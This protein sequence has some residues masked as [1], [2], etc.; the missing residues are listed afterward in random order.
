V[1]EFNL[2]LINT[3]ELK[4]NAIKIQNKAQTY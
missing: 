1:D 2:N 4:I 3:I